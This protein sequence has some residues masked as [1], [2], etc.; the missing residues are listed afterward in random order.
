MKMTQE[1][2]QLQERIESG[3]AL[4]IA[5]IAPPKGP[6]ANE[7]RSRAK[8]YGGRV[9]ALGVSATE[10]VDRFGPRIALVHVK[11][12][13]GDR[14]VALG[15][16]EVDIPGLFAAMRAVNYDGFYVI[17]INN[18]DKENTGRYFEEAVTYLRTKCA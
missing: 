5:E 9:H 14:S 13:I 16:G 7:V 10:V 15:A 2:T 17:E 1:K 6:D 11:D 18:D 3:K 12:M 4:L 8:R